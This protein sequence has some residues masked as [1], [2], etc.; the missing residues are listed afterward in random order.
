VDDRTRLAVGVL[1]F[2]TGLGWFLAVKLWRFSSL[3]HSRQMFWLHLTAPFVGILLMLMGLWL[4]ATTLDRIRKGRATSASEWSEHAADF[5]C[6][7][8]FQD[9]SEYTSRPA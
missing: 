8:P 5:S 7:G 3:D 6:H 9:Q 1:L 4:A 2:G